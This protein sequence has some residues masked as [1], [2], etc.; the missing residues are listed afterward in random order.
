MRSQGKENSG[1]SASG[2]HRDQWS[3]PVSRNRRENRD[4]NNEFRENE[5]QTGRTGSQSGRIRPAGLAQPDPPA[6]EG[7]GTEFPII[8]DKIPVEYDAVRAKRVL[9][10][11]LDS[12]DIPQ[13]NLLEESFRLERGGW[14]LKMSSSDLRAKIAEASPVTVTLDDTSHVLHCASPKFFTSKRQQQTERGRSVFLPIRLQ[15]LRDAGLEESD[16]DMPDRV[17]A[18][19]IS[20]LA[21]GDVENVITVKKTDR[22][23]CLVIVLVEGRTRTLERLLKEPLRLR[24]LS[25]AVRCQPRRDVQPPPRR[26]FLCLRWGHTRD[27]CR[28][29]QRCPIC[30][31]YGHSEFSCPKKVQ[32]GESGQQQY[33]CGDCSAVGRDANHQ[34][35]SPE[36]RGRSYLDALRRGPPSELRSTQDLRAQAI[37][38]AEMA[39][40]KATMS[41]LEEQLRVQMQLIRDQM[42][43]IQALCKLVQVS[44]EETVTHSKKD[45]QELATSLRSLVSRSK[46]AL[47]STPSA[48][49]PVSD[50]SHSNSLVS[51]GSEENDSDAVSLGSSNGGEGGT[52]GTRQSSAG[53]VP[54]SP[55]SATNVKPTGVQ[56]RQNT[57][58][59]VS[60]SPEE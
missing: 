21:E 58:R 27:T 9:G 52:D 5:S 7:E 40:M 18:C 57:L 12:L 10:K 47:G 60:P 49:R 36:C 33:K 44:P 56:T 29:E 2:D 46:R 1:A 54:P 24:D 4:Q 43:M 48:K 34:F 14:V 31:R 8:I 38:R 42:R 59:E 13:E 45:P 30:T 53:K 15:V 19:I 35:G 37:Q 55:P 16:A 41:S 25:I 22:V 23:L 11:L 6:G 17:K 32:E 3:H 51:E 39:T 20:S 26:C 28:D 50:R